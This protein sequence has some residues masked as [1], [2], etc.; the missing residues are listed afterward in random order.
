MLG[1]SRRMMPIAA[2][3][4]V[5]SQAA[6]ATT[7]SNMW[8][9]PTSSIES[10]M[11]SRLTREAFIPSV[12]I[13]MPSEM[14]MVL[15]SSGVPPA[16]QVEVAGHRLD[17][18]V[19]DADDRLGEVLVGVAHALEVG[20]RGGAVAPFE[21]GTALVLDI[22]WLAGHLPSPY[23]AIRFPAMGRVHGFGLR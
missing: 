13:V 14:A 18:G 8:P 12:P 10:A 7:A 5:L 15:N 22:E 4:I 17:P 1:T 23:A 21:Q 3:G 19:G 2:P 20:A 9:R 6:R 11:I 16:A